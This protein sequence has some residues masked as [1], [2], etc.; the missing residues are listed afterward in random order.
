MLD[1]VQYQ[2]YNKFFAIIYDNG[3]TDN[4]SEIIKPYLED[5]RFSYHR[6]ETNSP[7][8]FNLIFEQCQTE[9]LLIVHDDDIMLPTMAEKEI[10][11]LEANKNISIV[12]TNINIIDGNDTISCFKALKTP[13]NE[14]DFITRKNEYINFYINE[15]N[16]IVCPTVMFRMSVIRTYNICFKPEVGKSCDTFL[17]LEL[18]QLPYE[19][20]Y[21]NEALYNYRYHDTQDSKNNLS[22]VP[23]LKIPVYDLLIKNNYPKQTIFAW[24][25]YVNNFTIDV[26]QKQPNI[27]YAYNQIRNKIFIKRKL[28]FIFKIKIF[29]LVY[30]YS[31][32]RKIKDGKNKIFRKIKNTLKRILIPTP[33][34][35][36]RHKIYGKYYYPHYNKHIMLSNIYPEMFNKEGEKIE[37]YFI[38]DS[39]G[40]HLVYSD[41]RYFN[42]DRYNFGLDTHFY[43]HNSMLE[44]MGAP[45]KKF[46]M[47]VEAEVIVPDDYKIFSKNKGLENDFNLIFTYSDKILESIPN[48]RYV[49]YYIRPWYGFSYMMEDSS[50]A[51]ISKT[52][53]SIE[54]CKNKTKNISMI[55]SGKNFVPLHRFRNA[56]AMQCKT[57][58]IADTY[59]TFDGGKYCDISEPFKDY[60]FSIV[61]ENEITSYGFTEKITNCFAA[62]TI[63]VYLGASKIDKL[64][65][66]DGII[67][68]SAKDDIK[69][70][71]KKCTKEFY[72]ERIPAIIDNFNRV[73]INKSAN[74]IIY[75][76]Y[77][78]TDVGKI[79]PE[80]L[81]K[82]LV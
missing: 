16:Y 6:E 47:L 82:R 53:L 41:S 60:R 36:D 48:S 30:F 28:E 2:T 43:T 21:I 29:C 57:Q 45:V 51:K 49:P 18:N 54:N 70:I 68:F 66:I 78:K 4:T 31:L 12:S 10:A 42:W 38:R 61:V 67:Q 52:S 50:G 1:S 56:I 55:A 23:L 62:M 80:E 9:Y 22:M 15:I 19:F 40:S 20:Y 27:K 81:L 24:I 34:Y 59:G 74:D 5:K 64:F 77:L 71:V 13:V 39:H 26:L 25:R 73:N 58:K 79:A 33:A 72:E 11:I 65:N 7:N 35:F 44:T 32:H 37:L 17:W 14:M 46:G 75:E 63:P 3:S 69:D 8:M 76:N